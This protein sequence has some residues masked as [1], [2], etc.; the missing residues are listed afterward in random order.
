MK[1]K[2]RQPLV[3]LSHSSRDQR[4]VKRLAAVLRAHGIDV[5][6]SEKHIVGAEQWHDEIGRALNR[7]T[8]FAVILSPAAVRSTWVK[9]ELL[10]ALEQRTYAT[11]II[12]ILYRSCNHR[13][14]SWTLSAF[15]FIDFTKSESRGFSELLRIW[16]VRYDASKV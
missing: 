7:S 15:Q 1:K 6:Y 9:R 8:W 16:R 3:F 11:R 12:P 5:W 4:F 10:F 13:T 14:L 2:R